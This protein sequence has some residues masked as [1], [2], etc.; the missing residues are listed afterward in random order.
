[1]FVNSVSIS[2]N[3]LH[4]NSLYQKRQVNTFSKPHKTDQVSFS[5]GLNPE[6]LKNQL[7]IL[8]TQDIWS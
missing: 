6:M 4:S 2:N 5:G 8:L 1:M 3:F 7:R